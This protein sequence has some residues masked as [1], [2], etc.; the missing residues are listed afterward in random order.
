MITLPFLFVCSVLFTVIC[1]WSIGLN[2]G[3]SQFFKFLAFLFLAIVAAEYQ[4]LLIA[5]IIPIFIAALAVAA[6]SFGFLMVSRR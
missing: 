6:F 2:P 3:A 4:T 5:S 1:Y